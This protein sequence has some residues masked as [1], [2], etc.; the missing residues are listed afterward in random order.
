MESITTLGH[1][2]QQVTDMAARHWDEEIPVKDVAFNHL[3]SIR[4]GLDTFPLR[5]AA[6]RSISNK[7]GVPFQYLARSTQEVQAYNLNHWLRRENREKLL[8]RFDGDEVRAIF[9]IKYCAMDNLAVIDRM[10]EMGFDE[11]SKVQASIDDE[12][13]MLN[14]PN[15]QQAFEIGKND[16]MMP[17]L[18]IANSEVG[19]S[20]LKVSLFLL[21]ILCTNGLLAMDK[22]AGF[23]KR[24]ISTNILPDLPDMIR[25]ISANLDSHKDKLR[26][27]LESSVSNPEETLKAFNRQFQLGVP[28]QKAVEWGWNLEGVMNN[29]TMWHVI[30]TY[31][32][33]SQHKDLSAEQSYSLQTV[34]GQ[35]LQM[36]K[37]A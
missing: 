6:A 10:L 7:L 2:H 32:K 26:I 3:Q 1:V 28:E 8:F 20:S 30:N 16:K 5:P 14:V 11:K 21:R 17:G 34:G 18:G 27:S 36:V 23:S 19:L 22:A 33:A 13:M 31:T 4:I 12:F 15:P 25:N 9:S 24:H 35:V 29:A 37:A